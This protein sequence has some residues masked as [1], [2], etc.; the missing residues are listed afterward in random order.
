[1]GVDILQTKHDYTMAYELFSAF[2]MKQ[3]ADIVLEVKRS[4]F[5]VYA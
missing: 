4:F 5:A 1:M 2:Q 3:Y